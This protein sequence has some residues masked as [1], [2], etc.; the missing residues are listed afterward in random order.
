MFLFQIPYLQAHFQCRLWN[1]KFL[2]HGKRTIAKTF[3]MQAMV[4]QVSSSRRQE[5][6][7]NLQYDYFHVHRLWRCKFPNHLRTVPNV[8]GKQQE[9][10]T[11]L[12]V[13]LGNRY[14]ISKLPPQQQSTSFWSQRILG[15]K[16]I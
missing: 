8:L 16:H 12:H 2:H 3:P 1:C 15:D 7:K 14:R 10:A 11:W 13:R 9:W 4:L 5:H 6:C